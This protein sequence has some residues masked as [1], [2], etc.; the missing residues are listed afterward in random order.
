MPEFVYLA[1]MA[2]KIER[3]VGGHNH[4]TLQKCISDVYASR[5]M[6]PYQIK[7]CQNICFC[8]SKLICIHGKFNKNKFYSI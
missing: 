6:G 8:Q 3:T 1:G 5:S 2:V 4:D 7:S